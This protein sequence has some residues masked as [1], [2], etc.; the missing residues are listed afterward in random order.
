MGFNV[1]FMANQSVTDEDINNIGYNLANTVYTT[2]TNDTLYG[3]DELNA[4]TAHM[5][6]KG[7]KRNYKNECALTLAE[8]IVH[9]DSG[10]A[11]FENGAVMTID[12]DGIDLTMENTTETQYIYLF[13]NAALNA[14]GARVTS[15]LP[16]TGTDYVMLGTV[17]DGVLTQDRTFAFLNADVKGTNEVVTLTLEPIDITDEKNDGYAWIRYKTDINITKFKR[18]IFYTPLDKVTVYPYNDNPQ[19]GKVAGIID[20]ENNSLIDGYAYYDSGWGQRDTGSITANAE[21]YIEDGYFILEFSNYNTHPFYPYFCE[22]P[23]TVE[24]YGG[25]EE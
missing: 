11:F 23:I 25:A 19:Q 5:M 21:G 10:L 8:S 22:K 17:T 12:D 18:L 3:V 20:I 4:I 16:E 15:A 2:F 14:A 9:I 6:H 24:L 13:Y 1:S 7:V